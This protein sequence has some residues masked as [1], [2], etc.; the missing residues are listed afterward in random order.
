MNCFAHAFPF[1]NDPYFAVGCCIPDWLS[2]VDRKVRARERLATKFIDHQD[3]I[4][5]KLAKGVVQHHRDDHWFHQTLAFNELSL[6]FAVELR[7]LFQE[8]GMRPGLIGHIVVELFLDAW[9]HE[10]NPG[11]LEYFYKQVSS[12]D[13]FKVQAAVNQFV[14]RQTDGLA[15]EIERFI[16]VRYLFD[17]SSNEGMIFRLNRVFTVI[18]LK[19][20]SDAIYGWMPEA[21]LKTYSR[22]KELLC[23]RFVTKD[24][25]NP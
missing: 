20:I 23:E 4:V 9:I 17:Y 12:V 16:A 10:Q 25:P 24:S 18:R 1:L 15:K 7:E 21:R 11:R 19:P 8:R 14:T 3:S 5:A 22:A 13:P 6:Q 2:A